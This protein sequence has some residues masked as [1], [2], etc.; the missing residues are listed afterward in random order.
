[1]L[2]V[3]H[4]RRSA[5]A[6]ITVSFSRLFSTTILLHPLLV[7]PIYLS[8]ISLTVP[9]FTGPLLLQRIKAINDAQAAFEAAARKAGT[10][11][12]MH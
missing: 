5:L 6:I 7:S 4:F 8:A 11:N 10:S 1:M 3:P 2:V 9:V 12:T